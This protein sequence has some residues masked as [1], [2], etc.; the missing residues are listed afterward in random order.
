MSLFL[1]LNPVILVPDL[2]SRRLCPVYFIT[3]DLAPLVFRHQQ[4][5][6]VANHRVYHHIE[7]GGR[8]WVTLGNLYLSLRKGAP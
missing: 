4:V 2:S 7:N 1:P 8:Q 5:S 3:A 6:P